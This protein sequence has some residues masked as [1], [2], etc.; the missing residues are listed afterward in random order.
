M[1]PSL[2]WKG[3]NQK[4]KQ[5]SVQY[6]GRLVLESLGCVVFA[7]NCSVFAAFWCTLQLAPVYCMVLCNISSLLG[8]LPSHNICMCAKVTSANC[9]VLARFGMISE[10]R[11]MILQRSEPKIFTQSNAC[12]M[13]KPKKNHLHSSILGQ[14]LAHHMV[15]AVFCNYHL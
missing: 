14:K 1:V 7:R 4:A 15:F 3:Q 12:S 11:V 9:M 10:K 2:E 5:I 8:T 6:F 13:S